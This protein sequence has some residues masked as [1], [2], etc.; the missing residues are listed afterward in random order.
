MLPHHIDALDAWRSLPIK[1][2]PQWP[3]QDRLTAATAELAMQP[4]LVFAGEADNLRERLGAAGEVGGGPVQARLREVRTAAE[5]P[6]DRRDDGPDLV[7]GR[8]FRR[9]VRRHRAAHDRYGDEQRKVD[10]TLL[11]RPS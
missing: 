10:D 11:V 4:P 5:R 6:E 8:V 1:Q 9:C 7:N 3:D 2:Q